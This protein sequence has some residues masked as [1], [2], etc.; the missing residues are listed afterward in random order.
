M[1][2]VRNPQ[3]MTKDNDGNLLITNH[4]AK[5]GDFIGFVTSGGNYGWNK[6]GWGGKN[7]LTQFRNLMKE[8]MLE[9]YSLYKHLQSKN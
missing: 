9:L 3:G 5:G 1:I 2:G 6:I 4:G 8:T 7:Y